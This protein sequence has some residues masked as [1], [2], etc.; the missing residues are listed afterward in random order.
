[1]GLRSLCESGLQGEFLSL[2]RDA[3][4]KI[5]SHKRTVIGYSHNEFHPGYLVSIKFLNNSLCP[6]LNV[7]VWH[8]R[9][10]ESLESFPRQTLFG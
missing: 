5:E 1:M 9:G 2:S 6:V 3:L 10:L 8:A 4:L 7:A